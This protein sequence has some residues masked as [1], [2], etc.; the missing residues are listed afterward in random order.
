M[1]YILIP[2]YNV[3]KYIRECLDSVLKQS[4]QNFLVIIIDDGS[5]DKSGEICDKYAEKD[6]RIIV[7]HQKNRGSLETRCNLISYLKSHYQCDEDYVIMIDSDDYL[8]ENALEVIRYN[9]SQSD[10]DMLIYSYRT[11][12]DDRDKV[13]IIEEKFEGIICEPREL[14]NKVFFDGRY[15]ALWRKA[16]RGKVITNWDYTEYYSVSRSDDL[17]L[18]IQLYENVKKT[19]FIKETLYN[20][21]INMASLTQTYSRK[22]LYKTDNQGMSYAFRHVLSRKFLSIKEKNRY[23]RLCQ[24]LLLVDVE[25]A[26]KN[27]N[28]FDE[29]WMRLKQIREDE[30]SDELLKYGCLRLV[31]LLFKKRRYGVI[32]WLYSIKRAF[33]ASLRKLNNIIGRV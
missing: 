19:L 26:I 15:N 13:E 16:V 33:G 31:L 32:I 7:I 3:E 28:N 8:E 4:Y 18:D 10:C 5:S 21:R 14:Y 30:Y 24:N 2:V 9:T 27:T 25:S 12:N 1:F 6:S 11:F 22:K 23:T 20:Y 17:I 29:K